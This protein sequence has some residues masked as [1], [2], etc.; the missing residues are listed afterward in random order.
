MAQGSSIVHLAGAKFAVFPSVGRE[1]M[2][3]EI[4]GDGDSGTIISIRPAQPVLTARSLDLYC[5]V[6]SMLSKTA[7]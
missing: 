5:Q 3:M 4:A 7:A 1:P 6:V 2:G